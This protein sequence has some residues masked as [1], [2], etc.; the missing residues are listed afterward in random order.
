VPVNGAA[1]RPQPVR[2]RCAIKPSNIGYTGDGLPKLL[3]FGL[4]AMLGRSRSADGPFPT[5]Q[6]SPVSPL[7]DAA[8]SFSATVSGTRRVVGTPLYLSPEALAGHAPHPSF[9][10]WS[11]SL[12]LYEAL[13]GRHPLGHKSVLDALSTIQRTPI[14]DVRDVRPECPPAVAAFFNDALS[15][16]PERRP[17]SASELRNQ[18]QV[19]RS[20]PTSNKRCP[21][22]CSLTQR[23]FQRAFPRLDVHRV[24]LQKRVLGSPTPISSNVIRRAR[25]SLRLGGRSARFIRA[26]QPAAKT[27]K[28]CNHRAVT[29][30]S[31]K[32]WNMTRSVRAATVAEASPRRM[33]RITGTFYLLTVLAG[34]F[35][36]GFV[37]NRLVVFGDASATAANILAHKSLFRLSF[38]VFMIEMVCNIAM[39]V[40]FYVLLKP[41]GRSVSLL[42]GAL[43]L[44]GCAIKAFSRVF[45][46]VPLFILERAPTMSAFSPEQWRA[47]ALLLL[48]VNDHGAG[49][50]LAFAGLYAVLTG[51]LILRSTF[52]PRILGVMSVVAGAGWLTFL[53]PTLG[54][55]LFV[56][57]APFGLLGAAALIAWLLI[58]GVDEQ[59][60]KEQLAAAADGPPLQ[61]PR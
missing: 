55:S 61:L 57:V 3:D 54:P 2:L 58:R 21:E 6:P 42:A 49:M 51:Y 46:I 15:L 44:T 39:I 5:I 28:R 36:Q 18:L 14:P 11:L 8:H 23:E 20:S 16:A 38:T 41:A 22:C 32:G 53:S 19:L 48:E 9:D 12:V 7:L 30:S 60:W 43:G 24:D 33:A 50:A 17:A 1:A 27:H 29:L 35:A 34:L 56:Y 59:R 52:L 31:T 45:Y 4:A 25:C 37:S 13:V 47:Q 10:L 40:F 26:R